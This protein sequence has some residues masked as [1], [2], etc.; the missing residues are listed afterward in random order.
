[1]DRARYLELLRTEGDALSIAAGKNLRARVPSCPEWDV[2]ELIRHIG[3][4]HR[5]KGAIV[6]HEGTEY[7]PGLELEPAPAGPEELV[8]WYEKGLDD[9]MET[10]SSRDPETPAWS[11]AGDHRVAFWIRR[12]AQET[13]VH[14]WDVEAAVAEPQPIDPALSADGID[15]MLEA[16]IPAE[17]LPYE[18]EEGTVHLHCTDTPGEWTVTLRRGAVPIYEPG[19]SKGDAAVRGTASDLLLL[20]WR[21]VGLDRLEVHGDAQLPEDFWRYLEGPGQ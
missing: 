11:W 3:Q 2:A 20:V 6:R 10:L 18:G 15:E 5:H 21:R 16:F 4:V 12:M 17:A 19:H 9:L 7:P 13:A 14:R 1:V 8:D